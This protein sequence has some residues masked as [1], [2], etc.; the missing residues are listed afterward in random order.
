MERGEARWNMGMDSLVLRAMC[1]VEA[2]PHVVVV[3][4]DRASQTPPSLPGG[5]LYNTR[6][7]AVPPSSAPSLMLKVC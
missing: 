5:A 3:V 4:V 7:K 6:L 1:G 2:R